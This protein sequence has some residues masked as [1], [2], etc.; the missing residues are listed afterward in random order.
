[1]PIT[2]KR[3]KTSA[4]TSVHRTKPSVNVE[5]SSGSR[6]GWDHGTMGELRFKPIIAR[7]GFLSHNDGGF[8]KVLASACFGE[9]CDLYKFKPPFFE[10]GAYRR[11]GIRSFRR[12]AVVQVTTWRVAE[13]GIK[14][15]TGKNQHQTSSTWFVSRYSYVFVQ[16]FHSKPWLILEGFH[17]ERI[18]VSSRRLG[19]SHVKGVILFPPWE[20]WKTSVQKIDW[21]HRNLSKWFQVINK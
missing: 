3:P 18:G 12:I 21:K 14:D 9:P 8:S 15:V 11:W 1:M 19:F 6:I 5:T 20:L 16:L 7:Q 13:G 4:L 17:V 2:K 10:G